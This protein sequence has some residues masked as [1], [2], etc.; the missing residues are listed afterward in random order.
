MIILE[1]ILLWAVAGAALLLIMQYVMKSPQTPSRPELGLGKRY[2]IGAQPDARP[3]RRRTVENEVIDMAPPAEPPVRRRRRLAVVQQVQQ[4]PVQ[5]QVQAP[6]QRPVQTPIQRPVQAPVPAPIQAPV[7]ISAHR[8]AV[9]QAAA[10]ASMPAAIQRQ[11]VQAQEAVQSTP[12]VPAISETNPKPRNK[13]RT[14][15]M[16]MMLNKAM[17]ERG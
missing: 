1:S 12:A 15:T 14:D 9:A 13:K 8:Q 16:Q 7:Q 3:R 4:E 5:E 10:Q 2:P 6:V 11:P 17:S